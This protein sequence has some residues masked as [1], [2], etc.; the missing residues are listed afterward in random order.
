[1]REAPAALEKDTLALAL[2]N[3]EL[4]R[5]I[6]GEPFYFLEAKADNDEPQNVIPA[7]DQLVVPFWR[8]SRDADFPKRFAAALLKAVTTYPDCNR[9]L[10]VVSDW[11][12]Y[13]RFCLM[14]KQSQ[15]QGMYAELFEVDL[16]RVALVLKQ[17]LELNKVALIDDTRWAGATWNSTN[18][19]WGPILRTSM[20]VRDKLGGPDFVPANA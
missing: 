11:I 19:M 10:Y 5:F 4:D 14:K 8:T 13:Y 2:V 16:G 1:M 17:Q 9:A 20:T 12:W 18:G 7:F 3:D 6:V 15:P